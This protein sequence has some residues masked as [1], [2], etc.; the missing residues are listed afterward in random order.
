MIYMSIIFNWINVISNKNSGEL[1]KISSLEQS[2]AKL[3]W[4]KIFR[5]YVIVSVTYV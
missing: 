5:S 2:V 4:F 3:R 1:C